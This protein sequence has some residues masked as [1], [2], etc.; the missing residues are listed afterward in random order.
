MYF[1]KYISCECLQHTGEGLWY[2][3]SVYNTHAGIRIINDGI[4]Y[5]CRRVYCGRSCVVHMPRICTHIHPHPRTP[6]VKP[7]VVYYMV[8]YMVECL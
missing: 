7:S 3:Y 6:S 5:A 8:H 1:I 4:Q 2:A